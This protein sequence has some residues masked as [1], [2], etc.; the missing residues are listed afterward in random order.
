VTVA[1][2]TGSRGS[3][4]LLVV[5]G[6][7][8][9]L[10]GAGFGVFGLGASVLDWA[11]MRS[12]AP[13]PAEVL[14]ANLERHRSDK[15]TTYRATATY[16]YQF[17][18]RSYTSGRVGIGTSADNLGDWHQRQH[19]RLSDALRRHAPVTVWVNPSDPTEAVA[20]RDL[21]WGLLGFELIFV[22]VFGGFGGAIVWFGMRRSRPR[23]AGVDPWLANPA[24]AQNR[25]RSDART[26]MWVA[27]GFALIWNAL[28][29]PVVFIIPGELAKGNAPAWVMALFPLVGAGLLLYA[30]RHTLQWRRFGLTP[31]TLTPFPGSLGGQVAGGLDLRLPFRPGLRAHCTLSCLH[32]YTTGSGKSRR[33]HERALWQDQQLAHVEPGSRGTRLSFDFRTPPGLPASEDPSGDYH[34]W[35]LQVEAQLPGVDLARSYTIPVFDTGEASEAGRAPPPQQ[36]MPVASLPAD[37]VRIRPAAEGTQFFYPLF[38]SLSVSM[39]LLAMGALFTGAGAFLFRMRHDQHMPFFFP[40]VFGGV[41]ALLLLG[42]LYSLGNSLTVNASRRGAS[43]RRRVFGLTME[44]FV[45]R[46]DVE[47]LESTVGWQTSSGGRTRARYRLKLRDIDGRRITV[48]D[49]LPGASAAEAVMAQ[50]RDALGLEAPVSGASAPLPLRESAAAPEPAAAQRRA[51]RRIRWVVRLVSLAVFAYFAWDF[52]SQFVKAWH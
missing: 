24:W 45:A 10:V 43:I 37:I 1:L 29:A 6:L 48:G 36:A 46:E 38:R 44:R 35:T 9:L 17:Q 14:A 11:R 16:R 47:A 40:Y 41:G 30:L 32:V 50:M 8:F 23:P 2:N 19:Q 22:V 27:W 21:R 13:A 52:L 39:G 31:L 33:T 18:G 5:F 49:S 3:G 28:S 51:G 25:I 4:R 7:V 15:S 26:G 42:G 34:K 12:W 20:N